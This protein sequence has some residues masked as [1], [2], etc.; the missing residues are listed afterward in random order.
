VLR[1]GIKDSG[2][3]FRLAYFR[4]ASGLNEE[5]RR[6]YQANL[7]GVALLRGLELPD[8]VDTEQLASIVT[9]RAK[10]RLCPRPRM[11]YLLCL[12]LSRQLR[13]RFLIR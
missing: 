5:T 3:K 9:G 13:C 7:F 2:V 6:L 8:I 10:V 11:E 1:N 4:P 12:L